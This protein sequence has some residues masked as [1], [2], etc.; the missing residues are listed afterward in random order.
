MRFSHDR[1]ELLP[2]R[3]QKQR[4]D[5]FQDVLFARVVRAE[6][7]AGLFV[8]HA[9]EHRAEDGGGDF[10]P[11]ERGAVENGLAHFGG[12]RG[13]RQ[14]FGEQSAVDVGELRDGLVAA[15][16]PF[17]LRGVQHLEEF[18]EFRREVAA[19]GCGAFAN[20]VRELVGLEYAGIFGEEAEE[21]AHEIDFKRMPRVADGLHRVVEAGHLL[22]GLAVHGVLLADFAAVVRADHVAEERHVLAQV[23]QGELGERVV[24]FEVVETEALKVRH[25]DGVGIVG[26]RQRAHVFHRLL[27]GG[28]EILSR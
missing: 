24:L 13:D 1:L 27:V 18:R 9:L 21:E 15:C 10:R 8:H 4:A 3:I 28:V 6:V 2:Q 11:V 7:V 26:G 23:L 19:V 16:K 22:G 12:E 5:E 17:L 25:D 14:H 20:A